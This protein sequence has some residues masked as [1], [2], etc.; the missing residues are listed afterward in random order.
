MALLCPA[1]NSANDGSALVSGASSLTATSDAVL[2]NSSSSPNP[3][4]S[5]VGEVGSGSVSRSAR[6]CSASCEQS[7]TPFSGVSSASITARIAATLCA[8]SA[9]P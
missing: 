8:I 2:S 7:G 6:T 3:C 4:D 9:V 5:T 1:S